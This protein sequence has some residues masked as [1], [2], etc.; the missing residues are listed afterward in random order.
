MSN[1]SEEEIINKLEAIKVCGD[2]EIIY[3]FEAGTILNIIK[4]QNKETEE[5]ETLYQKALNE[6]VIADK[7]I[8]EIK[9]ELREHLGFENRLK[10]ENRKP[11]EFNQG[12]FYVAQNIKDIIDRKR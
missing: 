4:K 5:K 11:D 1:L 6:L 7:M 9:L 8:D 10:K 2:K 12:S 3:N